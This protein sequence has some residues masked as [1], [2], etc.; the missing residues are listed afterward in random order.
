MGIGQPF[1]YAGMR[2][3]FSSIYNITFGW[4]KQFLNVN[5]RFIVTQMFL[6]LDVQFSQ[7]LRLGAG[8]QRQSKGLFQFVNWNAIT[9]YILDL[10][11]DKTVFLTFFC[12]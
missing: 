5:R 9:F 3:H 2:S 7:V 10:A 8:F 4:L 1:P 6:A 11:K 12:S